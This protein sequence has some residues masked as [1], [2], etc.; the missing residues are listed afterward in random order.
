VDKCVLLAIF[1]FNPIVQLRA[2]PNPLLFLGMVNVQDAREA[3]IS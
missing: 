2:G 1:S 3:D